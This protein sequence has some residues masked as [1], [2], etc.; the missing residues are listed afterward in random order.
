MAVRRALL[1]T[2]PRRRAVRVAGTWMVC[3]LALALC[4]GLASALTIGSF[5]T[6]RTGADGTPSTQAGAHPSF[7]ISSFALGQ[8]DELEAAKDV[9]LGLPQGFFVSP[10]AVPRCGAANFASFECPPSTQVGLITLRA[11]H[12]GDPSHLLGTAPVYALLPAAGEIARYGFVAPLVNLPVEVP[13]T[14]RS[15]SDYGLDLTFQN[16]SEEAA[17]AGSKLTL[18]G[19]PADPM[20]DSGRF[21][22][23]SPGA[24]A[25]CPGVEGTSC[26]V[27]PSPVDIPTRPL[28]HNPTACSGPLSSTLDV[29]TYE[30]PSNAL[31]ATFSDSLGTSGCGQSAFDPW[32][33]A[34]PTTAQTRS[35]SGLSLKLQVIDEGFHSPNGIARSRIKSASVALPAE[36]RLDAD[37]ANGLPTCTDAQFGAGTRQPITCPVSSGIGTFSMTVAGLDEP[38]DGIAYLGTPE[39]GGA[40]RL[41]LAAASTA[42]DVRL[43]GLLQPGSEGGPVTVSLSNLPQLP[44]EELQLKLAPELGLLVTPLKCGAYQAKG[45]IAPWSSPG[46]P[47]LLTASNISLTSTGPSG[48]PCPGPATQVDVTLSPATILA[49]G[50]STSLATATVSDDD[51]IPVPGDEIAFAS[52]DPGQQIGAVTDNEEGTYTAMITSSTTAGAA[53]ITATD[54]SAT[55]SVAGVATLTQL[56]PETPPPPALVSAPPPIAPAPPPPPTVTITRKPPSSTGDRTPTFRFSSSQPGS[57]FSCKLDGKPFRPCASPKTLPQLSFDSHT[58]SVRAAGSA[59]ALSAPATYRFTVR[60]SRAF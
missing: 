7:L 40:Y 37:L 44:L 20:H 57:S 18:W 3:L 11:D 54:S 26:I 34:A 9:R 23:G 21:G 46:A 55:P 53:T 45:T 10:D 17:L 38:L 25:N 15:G 29:N 41:L 49:D 1:T 39:P 16:L 24:P 59:G 42:V 36:L 6:S 19:A 33:L 60:R 58:F 52:T 12:G 8:A 13:V 27:G 31:S 32:L 50:S 4:P 48:G 2:P 43:V 22:P 30:H 56:A 51:E 28:L 5:E 47:S 14:V 35:P